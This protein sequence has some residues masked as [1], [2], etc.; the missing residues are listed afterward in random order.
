MM[1]R[2][3]KMIKLEILVISNVKPN[4]MLCFYDNLNSIITIRYEIPSFSLVGPFFEEG[5]LYNFGQN[6]K[7]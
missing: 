7:F 4:Q 5:G 1:T 3:A 2:S 6:L